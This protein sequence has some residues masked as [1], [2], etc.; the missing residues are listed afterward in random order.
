MTVLQRLCTSAHPREL[1]DMN[2]L[3]RLRL[4]SLHL[5]TSREEASEAELHR[6]TH[7]TSLELCFDRKTPTPEDADHGAADRDEGVLEGL[8]PDLASIR[9]LT[10]SHYRGVRWPRWMMDASTNQGFPSLEELLISDCP[11]LEGLPPLPP[12]LQRLEIS[13]C[14]KAEWASGGQ[15]LLSASVLV[16]LTIGVVFYDHADGD[17][18]VVSQLLAVCLRWLPSLQRLF[19]WGSARRMSDVQS[20]AATTVNPG[21]LLSLPGEDLLQPLTSLRALSIRNSPLL[22]SFLVVQAYISYREPAKTT[23]DDIPDNTTTSTV[24]TGSSSSSSLPSSALSITHSSSSSLHSPQN[25]MLMKE[26][27]FDGIPTQMINKLL[28]GMAPFK[29]PHRLKFYMCNEL[30][31]LGDEDCEGLNELEEALL[32]LTQS[33]FHLKFFDCANLQRLPPKLS[34]LFSLKTLE[35]L[36]CPDLESLPEAGLPQGL[37][38]LRISG[39]SEK[40]RERCHREVGADWHKISHIPKCKIILSNGIIAQDIKQAN[41]LCIP[42]I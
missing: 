23:G 40:L 30:G 29:H 34:C 20:N 28:R 31:F 18:Q 38:E 11:M 17:A 21:M 8:Q 35:I 42:R 6:K 7:L 1:K 2:E 32:A 16:D 33:L 5:V 4:G 37:Q 26:L 19:I 24:A 41:I 36:F 12:T 14:P 27:K 39:C 22:T 10:I 15:L 25:Q 13:N 9:T 3:R